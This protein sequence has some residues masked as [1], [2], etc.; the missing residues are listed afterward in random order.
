MDKSYIVV[1]VCKNGS[2]NI[3]ARLN[4]KEAEDYYENWVQMQNNLFV[5][6]F[7]VLDGKEIASTI[8]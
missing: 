7:N 3:S 4:A 5:K 1:R 2:G 6:I 8:F